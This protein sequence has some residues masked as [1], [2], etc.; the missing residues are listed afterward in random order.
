MARI[1]TRSRLPS[2]A[3]KRATTWVGTVEASVTLTAVT[4]GAKI[5]LLTFDVPDDRTIVRTRGNLHVESDQIAASETVIGAFGMCVVSDTAAGTGISAIPGPMST[6]NWD[7]WFVFEPFIFGFAFA[8]GV[9]FQENDGHQIVLD[10]KSMRKVKE[11]DTIALVV[12]S[13]V[14]GDGMVAGANIRQL[15]K[16]H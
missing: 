2:R 14:N 10:N 1:V 15:F 4:A 7:G 13:G 11:G 12:E 6:P 5:L 16:L 9:G 8:S 3:P